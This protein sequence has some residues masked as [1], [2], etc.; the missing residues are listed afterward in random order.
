MATAKIASIFWDELK[1]NRLYPGGPFTIPGVPLGAPPT[2]LEIKDVHQIEWGPYGSNNHRTRIKQL[3]ECYDIVTDL[4]HEWA[5]SGIQM[6]QVCHPGVWVVRERL[7]LVN[8]DGTLVRDGDGIGMFRE[9]TEAEKA[10]MWAADLEENQNAQREYAEAMFNI[11]ETTYNEE[12][13]MRPWIHRHAFSA[14]KYYGLEAEWTKKA[15]E[16]NE[17]A[18]PSCTAVISG[19]ALK[20][21]K[22]NA[23][24]DIK[25]YA[26]REAT[27]ELELR[28]QRDLLKKSA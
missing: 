18:C 22:C 8:P 12:P 14:A 7:P 6:S 21:P 9:A 3:V 15:S 17:K 11:A 5:N 4:V 23:V 13:R 26:A 24:V 28:T 20:C 10:E 27:I 19:K 25:G 2:I 1:A 16:R